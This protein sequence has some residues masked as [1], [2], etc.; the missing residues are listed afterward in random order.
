[1]SKLDQSSFYGGG[2]EVQLA[3][4]A[5]VA[6]VIVPAAGAMPTASRG[7]HAHPRL[8]SATIATLDA[9]GEAIVAF[10][11]SFATMPAVGCLLIE[12]SDSQPIVFKVKSW[13]QNAGLYT[14][15]TIK[16]YRSSVLPT[17][18]GIILIGPLIT[19]LAN[20]NV[21]GGSAAGAQFSCVALQTS[22]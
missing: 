5:P 2:A 9:N 6:E 3:D 4:N 17:L 20:F 7:D 12:A 13:T 11:R 16:G 22:N 21:F 8:T 10:T 18:S 19:A 14:G 15:C 1:M